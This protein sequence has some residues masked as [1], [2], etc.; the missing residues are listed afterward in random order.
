[1]RLSRTTGGTK[2]SGTTA[3]AARRRAT[4][5]RGRRLLI[6]LALALLAAI[7]AHL[8]TWYAPRSRPASPDLG[9]LP[10]QILLSGEGRFRLWLAY[11]HQ[12]LG[13]L[14]RTHPAIAAIWQSSMPPFTLFRA[15]PARELGIAWGPDGGAAAARVFP[16]FTLAAKAAGRLAR[17]PWLGGGEVSVDG[18]AGSVE[19]RGS[20]WTATW[21]DGDLPGAEPSAAPSLGATGEQTLLVWIEPEAVGFELPARGGLW[22]AS[23]EPHSIALTPI[24]PE[25]APERRPASSRPPAPIGSLA[26]RLPA[27]LALLAIRESAA[28]AE[29]LVVVD[30]EQEPGILRLP[31]A[32]LATT[33]SVAER[34][35]L[36]LPARELQ[37]AL[38]G[39]FREEVL[40]GWSLV[41]TDRRSAEV[42]ETMLARLGL[43]EA[44]VAG[45]ESWLVVFRPAALH[46]LA[47]GVDDALETIP[48]GGE[49]LRRRWRR[50]REWT[51][52]LGGADW[53]GVT[54]EPSLIEIRA[55]A[56]SRV[57]RHAPRV[58]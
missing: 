52:A 46:R 42:C 11:P 17:N 28:G 15:P 1:M 16:L 32:A 43:L 55:A 8:W 50:Y 9:D 41:A 20:L 23:L 7:A 45:S 36:S 13:S 26:D 14:G 48:V 56:G 2:G 25:E 58:D 18:A 37:D 53:I 5:P 44:P 29:A 27:E 40:N 57:D 3:S 22:S 39:R 12:T 10:V 6:A 30:Q 51:A 24:Q 33:G 54:V 34:R 38:G 19:W 31:S 4:G 35:A 21:G 47:R 49:R